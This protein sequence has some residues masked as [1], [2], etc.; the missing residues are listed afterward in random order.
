[1]AAVKMA[2]LSVALSVAAL[3]LALEILVS[4]RCSC[5]DGGMVVHYSARL[6]SDVRA[7]S[8]TRRHVESAPMPEPSRLSYSI[9][10]AME[11]LNLSR[12]RLYQEIS[13]G[14]LR[15]YTIGRRRLISH[16]A[17]KDYIRDREAEA[18]VT[19]S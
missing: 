1:M 11:E 4:G 17:L 6:Y 19:A 13:T 12:S 18:R 16:D 15:T 9:P 3:L 8:W 2:W 5:A 7:L 14:R 10:Q